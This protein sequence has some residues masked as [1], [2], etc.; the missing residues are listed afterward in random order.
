MKLYA[1]E[2]FTEFRCIADRCTHSC[3]IGWEI[4]VDGDTIGRYAAVRHPYGETVRGSI[5]TD[6]V[7]HFVLCDGDRCPHLDDSGLCRIICELGEDYLC[8]ICREHPRFYHGT[9]SRR[10]VGLGLSCEEACRIVLS[11]DGY[12]RFIP[13]GDVEDDYLESEFDSVAEREKIYAIIGDRTLPWRERLAL[14]AEIYSLPEEFSREFTAELLHSLE[15]LDPAHEDLLCAPGDALHDTGT[16]IYL[17]RA[18]AY[19]VFRHCTPADDEVE[20]R[21]ALGFSMFCESL[22]RSLTADG[23]DVLELA[24]IISEELEYSEDNTETIKTEFIF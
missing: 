12:G 7:P 9:G 8:D 1:P 4:D 5:S 3:C 13:I 18:F 19:F 6:D 14:V 23:G 17:E 2:Y 15:Y 21:A 16:E 22:L 24:R 11:S 20:F 10:E